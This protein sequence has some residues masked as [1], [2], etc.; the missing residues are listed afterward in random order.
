MSSRALDKL[1]VTHGRILNDGIEIANSTVTRLQAELMYR[2]LV[3]SIA[4]FW[5]AF[6]EDLCRE[7]LVR[8]PGPPA[9]AEKAVDRF[10][11]PTSRKIDELYRKALGIENV[12]DGWRGNA[13]QKS[14]KT[15]DEFCHTIDRLMQMR[16]D[17]AHGIFAQS[18]QPS[19]ADCQEF[20]GTVLLLAVRTD[21]RVS[22]S[23][24]DTMP[25]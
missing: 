6:H 13:L 18:Q 15:P 23:F 9:R 10:H 25:A 7:M 17:T 14:G 2:L 11:N 5:E 21:E 24:P 16:H 3:V 22:D 12:T 19:P 1:T 4:A 8:H 20:L